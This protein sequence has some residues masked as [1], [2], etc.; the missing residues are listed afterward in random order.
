MIV[1]LALLLEW[2]LGD[3]PNRW[4]PVAWFGRWLGWCQHRTYGDHWQHGVAGWLLAILP[5]LA[6]I[7]L[8]H[9]LIGWPCDIILLWLAIGWKSLFIHVTRVLDAP[10][11]EAARRA[12]AMIVS[13]DSGAMTREACDRAAL[14]SLAENSCDAVIAPL[15]WWLIAGSVGAAAYRMINTL[16]ASWGYRNAR[17]RHFGTLAAR[18]DDAANWIPA[19]ITALLLLACGKWV[20]WQTVKQQAATHPSPNA[21]W[22][23]AALA[24]A[25]DIRLGGPVRR[26][27]REEQRP[28]Y[29]A[30]PHPITPAGSRRALAIVQHALLSAA[31]ITFLLS[32]V[33]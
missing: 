4:H 27:G 26:G 23:E 12:V 24:F 1:S 7:V 22:P 11:V 14:E 2:W 17:Y 28:W 6:A 19:R 13:R 10:T 15:F 20:A 8:V 32:L 25:A 5:P 9:H 30:N 18:V 3:P 29:G 16:D 21:G 31:A 33:F